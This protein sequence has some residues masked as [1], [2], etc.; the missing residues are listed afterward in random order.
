M[1]WIDS[2]VLG[3]QALPWFLVHLLGPI[4][5]SLLAHRPALPLTD[6]ELVVL[7]ALQ[8]MTPEKMLFF[9]LKFF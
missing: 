2:S 4:L 3:T 9:I 6:R 7:M 1:I 5:L 8:M